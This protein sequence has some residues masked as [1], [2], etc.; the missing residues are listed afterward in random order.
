MD[1]LSLLRCESVDSPLVVLPFLWGVTQWELRGRADGAFVS[2]G[3]L[4][5]REVQGGSDVVKN[6][7]GKIACLERCFDL[8][9]ELGKVCAKIR[10]THLQAAILKLLVAECG[11]GFPIRSKLTQHCA[12]FT[13]PIAG[14]DEPACTPFHS[15][16][17]KV[18]NLISSH[19]ISIA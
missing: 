19:G 2:P 15:W 7:A 1:P 8:A 13:Q 5:D 10:M 17:V 11:N 6:F 9:V 12:E 16:L 14:L 4:T 18:G 3:D